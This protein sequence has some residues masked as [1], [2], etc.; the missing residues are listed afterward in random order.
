M[1]T[2]SFKNAFELSKWINSNIKNELQQEQLMLQGI[3]NN[4]TIIL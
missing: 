3:R 2:Y 1:K 4:Y